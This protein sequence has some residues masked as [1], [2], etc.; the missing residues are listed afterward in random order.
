MN[1]CSNYGPIRERKWIDVNPAT[2]SQSCFAVSK[3]MIRFMR[4]DQNILRE[5]D[6]AVGCD[7]FIEE[8][9]VKFVGFGKRERREEKHSTLLASL[10]VR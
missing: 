6:G 7:D 1:L 2:F 4:H 10:S 5:D 3:F 9:R 8:F